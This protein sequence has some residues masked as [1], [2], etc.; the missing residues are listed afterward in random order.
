VDHLLVDHLLYSDRAQLPRVQ[1]Q[2]PRPGPRVL[3][4]Q[5]VGGIGRSSG[6]GPR[7]FDGARPASRSAEGPRGWQPA[8]TPAGTA[9][10]PRVP[11][12]RQRLR[13]G[14]ARAAFQDLCLRWARSSPSMVARGGGWGPLAWASFSDRSHSPSRGGPRVSHRF[15]P[16]RTA[17]ARLAG[18]LL[19]LTLLAA[20]SGGGQEAGP[21]PAQAPG[22]SHGG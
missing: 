21:S 1:A 5:G 8:R 12:A 13:G 14:R 2:R 3:G 17:R 9:V 15:R 19:T 4:I 22:P 16:S 6:G 7:Q 10:V 11:P 20:G 18:A